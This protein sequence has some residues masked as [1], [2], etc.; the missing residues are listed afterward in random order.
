VPF[1]RQKPDLRVVFRFQVATIRVW[2][3]VVDITAA[4]VRGDG[5]VLIVYI[6]H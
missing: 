1:G 3:R 5:H 4:V 6:T 2:T